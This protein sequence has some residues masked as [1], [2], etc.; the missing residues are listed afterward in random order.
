MFDGSLYVEKFKIQCKKLC[1]KEKQM[2]DTVI[3]MAL[4][5][6]SGGL[7]DAYSYFI[8]GKVFANAQT[9][10]VVFMSEHI[11]LGQWQSFFKYL[12]PLL[13]F[14]A[15][16]FVATKIRSRYQMHNIFHWRQRIVLIE[17]I[18]LFI[19][20]MLPC[21]EQINFIANA[22]TSFAC[23]M[24]VQSFRKVNGFPY[25]STMCIGN[26][27]RGISALSVYIET[28]DDSF[29]HQTAH[30]LGVILLFAFGAGLGGGLAHIIGVKMIWISCILLSFTLLLMFVKNEEEELLEEEEEIIREEDA[31]RKR[32]EAL[33]LEELQLLEQEE[34]REREELENK[35]NNGN[36]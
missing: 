5:T 24:Q 30:Y 22:M 35:N 15:G 6:I 4:L 14:M 8:R 7:Q 20:G 34:E 19:V 31:L 1:D 10:N 11:F 27:R 12:I 23:A 18:L 26:M 32:E 17:V 2:S 16:V 36:K 13:A 29:L 21:T 3:V 28:G 9:G 33:E 25:A